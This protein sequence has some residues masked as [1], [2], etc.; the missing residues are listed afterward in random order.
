MGKKHKKK[1]GKSSGKGEPWGIV[2][3]PPPPVETWLDDDPDFEPDTEARKALT[4]MDGLIAASQLGLIS[5]DPMVLMAKLGLDPVKAEQARPSFNR[6]LEESGG[7]KGRRAPRPQPP[8]VLSLNQT[9]TAVFAVRDYAIDH[10]G[11][12]DTS[13]PRAY[14]SRD[15]K[16]FILELLGPGGLA[17]GVTGAEAAEVT[18]VPWATL[19]AWQ[20]EARRTS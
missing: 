16:S 2:T 12:I 19:S 1:R 6:F 15:F 11:S 3:S 7:F 18:G 14:Y 4:V 5:E 17:E 10:P 8:K 13:G 9:L 20:R